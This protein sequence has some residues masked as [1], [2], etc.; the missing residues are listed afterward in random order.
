MPH[1]RF[2]VPEA[3]EGEIVLKDDE[4]HHLKTVMR[5]QENQEIELVNGRWTL[6]KALVTS[7]GKKETRIRENV[8][9]C[10]SFSISELRF[11]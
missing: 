7:I 1:N 5:V 8:S 3:L 2:Y 6:A 9:V 4:H 10:A 11:S